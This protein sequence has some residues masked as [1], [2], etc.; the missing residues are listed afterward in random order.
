MIKRAKWASAEQAS[1]IAVINDAECT[2]PDDMANIDRQKI[3]EWE[4]AGN[5]IAAY[6]PP[7]PA[8]TDYQTA[9]QGLID[10]TAS[11]K[12]F[13]DGVSLA[14]YKD[15]TVPLWAAQA[16]AFIAWRD[17]VWVYCYAEFA[18]VEAGE[19]PQPT[20]SAFL[21]ELPAIVWPEG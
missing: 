4:A 16:S 17:G 21:A 12:L 10:Q 2:V 19:R 20:V 1:I 15:S 9:V 11:E 14:S 7:A 5:K 6:V 13:N 3:A 18:K 8:V